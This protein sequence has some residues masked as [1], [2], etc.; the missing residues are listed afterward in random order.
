MGVLGKSK[1][2]QVNRITEALLLLL[3]KSSA[4][5]WSRMRL[6]MRGVIDTANGTV[7]PLLLLLPAAVGRMGRKQPG[8]YVGLFG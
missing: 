3:P 1:E 5:M 6:R 7:L 4:R 2:R 8:F